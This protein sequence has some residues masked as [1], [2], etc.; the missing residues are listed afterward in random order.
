M[1]AVIL[2]PLPSAVLRKLHPESRVFRR[3]EHRAVHL[4]RP[5]D[6]GR[7]RPRDVRD[8]GRPLSRGR[9]DEHGQGQGR[10]ARDRE[11]HLVNLVL[12]WGVSP[13][14]GLYFLVSVSGSDLSLSRSLSLS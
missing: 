5:A 12:R 14:C 9:R 7:D 4:D 1:A 11:G 2:T 3:V 6:F 13:P 10:Q 8:G